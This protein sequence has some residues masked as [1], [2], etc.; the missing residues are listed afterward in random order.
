MEGYWICGDLLLLSPSPSYRHPPRSKPNTIHHY[1]HIPSK[2]VPSGILKRRMLLTHSILCKTPTG[3]PHLME[4]R[5]AVTGFK[6]P[7]LGP[8]RLHEARDVVARIHCFMEPHEGFPVRGN[9]MSAVL[10]D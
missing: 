9:G 1:F 10:R 3:R 5:Y 4:R 2:L 7:H 6:L 8:D